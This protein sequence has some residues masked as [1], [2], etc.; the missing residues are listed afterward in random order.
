MMTHE[1]SLELSLLIIQAAVT[2][3]P[4]PLPDCCYDDFIATVNQLI[5]ERLNKGELNLARG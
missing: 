1:H 3:N 4:I 2:G 5:E